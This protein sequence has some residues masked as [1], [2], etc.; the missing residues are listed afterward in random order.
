VKKRSP[1]LPEKRAKNVAFIDH[2][3]EQVG[4]VLD[5]LKETGLEQNTL[6]VFSA[7]NGGSIPHGQNNDPWRGGK[8]DHYDGGLR[9]PF[10]MRW[11]ALI[12]PGSKNDYAGLNFDLFPTFIEL[13]GGKPSIDLDAVSLVPIIKGENITSTRE[14]YFTRREGGM[15][16]GGK[17]Y[18]AL[19]RGEWKLLQN[20]PFAPLELYNIKSDPQ[21][22][23]NLAS[24]EP[25]VLNE[26]SGILR[27]HIQRGGS[28]PWQKP[29]E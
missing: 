3:D 10:L 12:K 18:E 22:K 17:S 13:A 15:A 2:L 27:T 4:Q 6:V 11:P 26:L 14:L 19:I 1:N 8:Q 9:I 20:T 16:Y 25:R 5:V 23:N 24:N 28:T 21:E 7:D 29:R